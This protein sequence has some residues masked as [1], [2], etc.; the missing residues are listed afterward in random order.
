V[1]QNTISLADVRARWRRW[2]QRDLAHFHRIVHVFWEA[3]LRVE[4]DSGTTDEGE[5]WFVFCDSQSGDILAQF[6]RLDGKYV[7]CAQF[8][9]G[10]LTGDVLAELAERFLDR[11]PGRR[12]QALGGR[13]TPAA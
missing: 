6:A 5:P 10:S 7:A 11:C 8:L 13:S 1:N 2:S 12:V 3:G 9:N 4:T